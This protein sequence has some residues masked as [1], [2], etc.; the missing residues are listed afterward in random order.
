DTDIAAR[1]G[2]EE[3]AVYLP[4]V[5]E[6]TAHAVAERIRR[7]VEM[8]TSPQVTI[9]SGLAKWNKDIDANLSVEALFYQADLALYEAKNSGRNQVVLA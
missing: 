9:S 8:E 1:W 2:G 5:D 3:L 7:C 4:R 6:A